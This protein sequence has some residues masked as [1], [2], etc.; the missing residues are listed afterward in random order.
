MEGFDTVAVTPRGEVDLVAVERVMAGVPCDLT[1]A[2][3]SY[4]LWSL[5]VSLRDKPAADGSGK[6][7]DI[8]QVRQSAP[9]WDPRIQGAADGLG[10][11]PRQLNG[12]LSKHR[13]RWGFEIP[14]AWKMAGVKPG[15][16]RGNSPVCYQGHARRQ[17]P[18]GKWY[19]PRCHGAAQKRL[20]EASRG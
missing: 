7:H 20:K 8:G 4:L 3:V 10:V 6:M 14:P 13:E 16:R 18:G 5:V 19:C 2:E 12:R 17:L 9:S 11:T 1:A 15:T